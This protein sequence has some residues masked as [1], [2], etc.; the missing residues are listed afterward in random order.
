MRLVQRG[1]HA[2]VP[3]FED[4]L[5]LQDGDVLVVA[6]TR[7]ALTAA[8]GGQTE[9]LHADADDG[10]A[11]EA[12]APSR[13]AEGGQQTVAEVMVTPTSRF[14][15]RSLEQ[16]GFRYQYNCIVLGIQRRSR[17]I[18]SMMTEIRL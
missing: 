8:M 2:F 7:R 13:A 4:A 18:R 6:A 12:E 5:V 11:V 10:E 14:L 1:E 9:L 15:G 17:M 3:P 16:I